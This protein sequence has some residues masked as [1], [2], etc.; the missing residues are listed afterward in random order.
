MGLG[1][2]MAAKLG[3]ATRLCKPGFAGYRRAMEISFRPAT[4]DDFDYCTRLYFEDAARYI[5]DP[6]AIA[7]LRAGF[8]ARWHAAEVRIITRAGDDIGWLQGVVRDGA[9]FI[10]Q[11]F[12]DAPLRGQGIGTAVLARVI[13]EAAAEGRDVSLGVVKANRAQRLYRRLGFHTT[14]EDERK[15]YMR[16]TASG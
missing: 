7:A 3:A 13:E 15:Y 16:R 5:D 6:A 10:I 9:F 8:P 12:V 1:S 2:L 4:A 11:L 14:H